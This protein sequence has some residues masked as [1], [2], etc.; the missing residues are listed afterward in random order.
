MFGKWQFMIF[1]TYEC[2]CTVWL[3]VIIHKMDLSH[4]QLSTCLEGTLGINNEEW[5]ND[6]PITKMSLSNLMAAAHHISYQICTH[7]CCK[8]RTKKEQTWSTYRNF[9]WEG[10]LHPWISLVQKRSLVPAPNRVG[11]KLCLC[12]GV[13]SLPLLSW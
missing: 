6:I 1:I 13:R 3:F 2:E 9:L 10:T 12:I 8:N 5:W 11:G 7:I 4:K